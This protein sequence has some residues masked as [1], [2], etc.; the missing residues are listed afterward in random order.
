M[1]SQQLNEYFSKLSSTTT[2]ELRWATV[3][4]G[5]V[6]VLGAYVI[7]SKND[8]IPENVDLKIEAVCCQAPEA[9]SC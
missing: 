3:V 8:T 9:S 2:P 4:L 6:L 7:Q 5:V 1:A